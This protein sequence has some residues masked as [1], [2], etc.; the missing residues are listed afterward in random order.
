[1][2][3]DFSFVIA[4]AQDVKAVRVEAPPSLLPAIEVSLAA[5]G[6]KIGKGK[7][8]LLVTSYTDASPEDHQRCGYLCYLDAENRLVCSQ[9]V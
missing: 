1:M 6:V 2:T 9:N 8:A 3:T 7:K 5:A 4:T